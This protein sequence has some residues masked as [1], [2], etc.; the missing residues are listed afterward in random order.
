MGKL[1]T[2]KALDDYINAA[3]AKEVKDIKDGKLV[4]RKSEIIDLRGSKIKLT[5]EQLKELLPK[6]VTIIS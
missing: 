4:E 6:G 5:Y 3:K 1:K 2:T